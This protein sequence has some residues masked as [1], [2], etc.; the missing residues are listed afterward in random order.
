MNRPTSPPDPEPDS[1][2]H[3]TIAPARP[4][5]LD[6]YQTAL[7]ATRLDWLI[8]EAQTMDPRPLTL[9]ANYLAV[10]RGL[11]ELHR[12]TVAGLQDSPEADAVRDVT[13]A[14]WQALTEMEKERIGELSEDLYSITDSE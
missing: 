14:P 3:G 10:V 13:D 11:R 6:D 1:A 12:L 2:T 9:S 5:P 4:V 7:A 8:D